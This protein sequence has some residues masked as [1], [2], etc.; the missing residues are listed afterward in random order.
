MEYEYSKIIGL[1]VF[2]ADTARP[3]F[4]INDVI[5]DPNNGRIIAFL[6][7]GKQKLVV[8]PHDI[9]AIK[10]GIW[11][12]DAG[13]LGTVEDVLRVAK[14]VNDFGSFFMKKVFTEEG[15]YLGKILDMY[16]D[17]QIICLTKIL[18]SKTFLGFVQYDSRVL[19]AKNIIDTTKDSVIVKSDDTK[20]KLPEAVRARVKLET[21]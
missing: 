17:S 15:K 3:V 2:K 13:D 6:T 19:P 16:F 5:I 1:P 14:V 4:L 21:A 12:R 7:H 11:I 10:H 20:N 8:T 18:V 9:L